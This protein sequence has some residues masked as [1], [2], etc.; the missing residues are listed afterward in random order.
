MMQN[1]FGLFASRCP[2]CRSIRYRNAGPRDMV[3]RAFEWLL[4]SYRCSLC[5][6]HFFL[7]RLETRSI[8]MQ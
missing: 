5:G 7:F 6:R 1:P 4:H 3:E 2:H 8:E